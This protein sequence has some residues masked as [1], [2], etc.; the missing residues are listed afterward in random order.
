MGC[1]YTPTRSWSEGVG[2]DR[3]VSSGLSSEG[4]ERPSRTQKSQGRYEPLE[5]A[6]S[7][8]NL[9]RCKGRRERDSEEKIKQFYF[10]P[11]S[12]STRGTEHNED[13]VTVKVKF[14]RV[15]L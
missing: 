11:S 2:T 15:L 5:G 3:T 14:L 7:G 13:L 1:R 8:V 10:E 6:R 4:S 12:Y 9:P